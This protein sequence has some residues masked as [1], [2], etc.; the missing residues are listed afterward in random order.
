[1]VYAGIMAAGIGVRMHRQDMPKQFLPLG[2]KPLIINT[3][4]QFFLNP[5]VDKIIVVAP[6]GWKQFTIDLIEKYDTMGT[7]VS[8][9]TGGEN[10]TS[11]I[12]MVVDFIK[13]SA[14]INNDDI[15]ITHDAVR[16]FVTQKLIDEN[17][18]I[19]VRYGA[20][21]TVTV[22]NDTII[23]S[24][25]GKVI[26]DVPLKKKMF[27]EQ[28][29]QTFNLK[30]LNEVFTDV[31]DKK[32]NLEKETELSRLYVRYG[33]VMRFVFGESSNMKIINPYDLEV[34]NALL[35]EKKV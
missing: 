9:I 10:K 24:E 31:I 25:D 20:A 21:S 8:V 35:K 33:N 15:L 4:E 13:E 6:D 26:S 17:I 16:P 29:P 32:I 18:E 1:M 28:T 3:L 11:S 2:E 19:T 14:Q 12:K 22:T 27:A 7:D 34:A 23:A 30:K 5:H